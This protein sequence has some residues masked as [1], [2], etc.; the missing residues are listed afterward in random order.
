MTDEAINP[1]LSQ[2][3]KPKRKDTHNQSACCVWDFTL[4]SEDVDFNNLVST[5][6]LNCK[7]WVF[8]KEKGE[9]TG[10]IHYQGRFS[11]FKKARKGPV[12]VAFSDF[13]NIRVSVT[14]SKVAGK[15][16]KQ[17]KFDYVL[18]VESRIEGPWTDKAAPKFIPSDVLKI[19]TLYPWQQRVKDIACDTT[20]DDERDRGI[21]YVCCHEGK[22]GKSSFI[23]WMFCNGFAE[24]LGAMDTA[25]DLGRAA[26]CLESNK[27]Y[28]FDLP[29]SLNKRALGPFFQGIEDLKNGIAV[30]DR[31]E[32][33][34]KLMNPPR[35]I[36]FANSL[37]DMRCLSKD[38]WIFWTINENLELVPLNVS[39]KPSSSSRRDLDN[40]KIS[41][42][43]FFETELSPA[44]VGS[45][46]LPKQAS[47]E[48]DVPLTRT[49]IKISV[50][51]RGTPTK[52]AVPP[53]K[54]PDGRP[55]F[56]E[57]ERPKGLKRN[58][59]F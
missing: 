23:K 50:P 42:A 19:K 52:V 25:K 3:E 36:I 54:E 39:Q 14:C 7:M 15:T 30:D 40:P 4:K 6:K 1:E 41:A 49:P 55:S 57:P 13:P 18:K 35:V 32:Y 37:P 12:L 51:D 5:L 16:S 20:D 22:K 10:F 48:A 53:S 21:H 27:C 45:N 28:L 38:R 26:Y 47:K 34:R 11:L 2:N 58:L 29:R 33:K 59:S 46:Y 31:Y 44:K 43:Q 24:M 9:E 17:T 8:Q 56:C